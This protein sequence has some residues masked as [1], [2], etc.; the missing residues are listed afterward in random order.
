MNAT[1]FPHYTSLNHSTVEALIESYWKSAKE[2]STTLIPRVDVYDEID[3]LVVEAELPGV[4]K[5]DI[6]VAVE[7]GV[8]SLKAT[9]KGREQEAK[10]QY[11]AERGFGSYA[12]SF[13]LADSLDTESIQANFENGVLR[14]SLKRK[15]EL[16]GRK[17]EIL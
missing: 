1:L 2:K 7:R 16:A 4:Q 11:F 17:I 3:Y 14:L 6:E 8:L 10:T 9:K 12:R 13:R 5:Q 15:P